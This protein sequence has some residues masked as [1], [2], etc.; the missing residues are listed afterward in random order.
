MSIP[1]NFNCSIHLGIFDI[2]EK[3]P[4]E[5]SFN[6]D[7][8]II[9]F[10]EPLNQKNSKELREL[11]SPFISI[12]N[13][14][15]IL[16]FIYI[17][18]IVI[19]CKNLFKFTLYKPLETSIFTIIFNHINIKKSIFS[20]KTNP[21]F[22][23]SMGQYINKKQKALTAK[24][25]NKFINMIHLFYDFICVERK[26]NAT[27]DE[28]FFKAFMYGKAYY[29]KST[30]EFNM[31]QKLKKNI[32][33]ELKEGINRYITE[34]QNQ[35][36]D[37]LL[38]HKKNSSDFSG[39]DENEEDKVDNENA[40]EDNKEAKIDE[41]EEESEINFDSIVQKDLFQNYPKFSKFLPEIKVKTS[42]FTESTI[43]IIFKALNINKSDL[44]EIY[45]DI[46][47]T[48]IGQR[49]NGINHVNGPN[50]S[51]FNVNDGINNTIVV[52]SNNNMM[53]NANIKSEEKIL[54]KWFDYS[55]KFHEFIPNNSIE[56]IYHNTSQVIQRKFFELLIKKF[57]GDIIT[58]ELGKNKVLTS[59]DFHQ[60]L[61]V[62][63]R[64]KKILFNNKNFE[65]Y[66]KLPFLN[67]QP[68]YYLFNN[69][70]NYE[71]NLVV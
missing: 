19:D 26:Y 56:N 37:E 21:N 20:F 42:Y 66:S 2:K 38:H 71:N 16:N 60:I 10:K 53:N 24:Y 58:L 25:I 44:D 23:F 52:Q 15:I 11:F 62:M 49:V 65:Y 7:S 17:K 12:E 59:N 46:N 70:Y 54:K 67:E 27:I 3:L 8:F 18:N 36:N 22:L 48:E 32:S 47:W 9:N 28:M 51:L 29:D 1:N 43:F 5:L 64:M 68:N 40:K 50:I 4:A 39:Y 57:F 55:K 13:N 30:N 6:E 14:M 45:N 34:L 69:D 33:S 61:N 31:S 41:E 63:R 35:K